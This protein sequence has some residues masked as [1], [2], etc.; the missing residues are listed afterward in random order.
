MP[1]EGGEVI[2]KKK[3]MP[4]ELFYLT[5]LV[6]IRVVRAENKSV[7]LEESRKLGYQ[8]KYIGLLIVG[9]FTILDTNYILSI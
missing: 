1:D 2:K 9:G 5:L 4:D 3:R 6:L 7:I 8:T